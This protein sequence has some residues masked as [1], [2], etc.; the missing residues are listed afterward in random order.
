MTDPTPTRAEVERHPHWSVT[1]ETSG[2]HIT[3]LE[4]ECYGGR[5]LS[6]ADEVAI[7]TAAHHL[8][9]FIGDGTPGALR[10]RAEAAEQGRREAIANSNEEF[11]E[12]TETLRRLNVAETA[13]TAA[14]RAEAAAWNDAIE[15]AADACEPF[16]YDG[17][18]DRMCKN[19]CKHRIRALRRAAPTEGK[20]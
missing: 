11:R 19:T 3:T 12:H 2:D 9:S 8:L 16:D 14:R 1:V 4:P 5:E 13:L 20:A 15:A 10:E 17:V 7:R 18:G 6:A